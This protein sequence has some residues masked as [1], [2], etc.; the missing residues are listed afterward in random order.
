LANRQRSEAVSAV[1]EIRVPQRQANAS[2]S[3][4]FAPT[5]VG[6]QN[7]GKF[8]VWT[9]YFRSNYQ[10]PIINQSFSD[11]HKLFTATT[12]IV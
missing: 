12:F 2:E 7:T 6:T 1:I 11:L 10:L 5:K 9:I 8:K 4:A 3:F